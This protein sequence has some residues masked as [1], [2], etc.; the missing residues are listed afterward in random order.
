MELDGKV[1]AVTG[2]ANGIGRGTALAFAERGCDVAL[3][4]VDTEGLS[5]TARMV[6]RRGVRAETAEVDVSE[7]RQV[8]QWADEVVD[9][10]GRVNIIVNNAGVSVTA[11]V[12]NLSYEDFEWLMSINF[13]GVVYGTRS[14]LPHIRRSGVGRVVN[15]SSIFGIIASPTQSAYNSAK[16]AV[17]GFTESLRAE[18][19][20]GD[21][22]VG[23]SCVHPGGVKTGIVRSS[24]IG[25]T[26]AM[27]RSAEEVVEEFEEELAR[28][29]PERAGEIIVEG[30]QR[31]KG[32]ILVGVD[33]KLLE[34]AQRLFP[35][36][37]PGPMAKIMRMKWS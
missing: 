35:S 19:E 14:F 5:E 36:Q 7:R 23:A 25:D 9:E 26:G 1:A 18:L 8:E 16:F 11:S 30:I 24:R 21:E 17:R 13:W 34:I 22:K 10:F 27:G 15:V 12:E 29:S 33:A 32:R 37:Y 3:S 4:D 6:E 2:A 28:L 31:E 20:L